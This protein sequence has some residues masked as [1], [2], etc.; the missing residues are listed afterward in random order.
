MTSYVSYIEFNVKDTK[1][2]G[3]FYK[4]VFGWDAQL[5]SNDNDYWI[6]AHGDAPGI[7]AGIQPLQGGGPA[8]VAVVTVPNLDDVWAKAMKAGATVA[9]EKFAIPLL[10]TRPTSVTQTA[11]SWACTNTTQ[12][13]STK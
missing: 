13:R 8:A 4:Q 10:A 7:D 9:M 2:S 3:E 12:T 6:V 11:S 5:F 1:K